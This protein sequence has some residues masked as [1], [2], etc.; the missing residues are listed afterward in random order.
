MCVGGRGDRQARDAR[1][2][3]IVF[4]TWQSPRGH[5]STILSP[6]QGALLPSEVPGQVARWG[7][8]GHGEPPAG[9]HP[10]CPS[11]GLSSPV[12]KEGLKG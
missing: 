12:P 5:R 11:R 7:G 10:P 1:K 9:P 6:A 8:V 4:W 2:A 3:E